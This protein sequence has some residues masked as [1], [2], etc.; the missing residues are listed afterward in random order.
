[1]LMSVPLSRMRYHFYAKSSL[2]IWH[3]HCLSLIIQLQ[4][5][6]PIISFLF[7]D[8]RNISQSHLYQ[9]LIYSFWYSSLP[10]N[11]FDSITLRTA[12][13]KSS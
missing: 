12:L 6:V 1:M 10:S 9:E 7:A 3:L 11:F 8:A 4:K 13:L 5:I 2:S